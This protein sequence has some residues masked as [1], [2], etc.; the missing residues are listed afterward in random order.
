MRRAPLALLLVAVP[1]SGEPWS[2]SAEAGGAVD[3][4]VQR[5]ETGPGL[6]TTPIAAGVLRFGVHADHKDRAFGGA[7]VL[8]ISDL[9]RYVGDSTVSVESVT[10]LGG[11][12]RWLHTVGE[13]P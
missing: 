12:L 4:N 8:G 7:Y 13:R 11:E 1:A 2:V 6:M 5:V 10:V 3:S 9:T